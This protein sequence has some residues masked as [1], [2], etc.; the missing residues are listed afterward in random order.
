[1]EQFSG[2]WRRVELCCLR[3]ASALFGRHF[4]HSE[5]SNFYRD[6]TTSHLRRLHSKLYSFTV[7]SDDSK[8]VPRI[9][10]V[11]AWK[12]RAGHNNERWWKA[13]Y[14]WASGHIPLRRGSDLL[15]MPP[16]PPRHQLQHHNTAQRWVQL[17]QKKP[18][19]LMDCCDGGHVQDSNL[20]LTDNVRSFPQTTH[21]NARIVT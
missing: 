9:L 20:G 12:E 16:P 21:S 5:T 19:T 11:S 18:E 3:L 13:T 7:A 17:S 14:R 1:M 2:S 6:Y 15:K 10:T 8:F 4:D